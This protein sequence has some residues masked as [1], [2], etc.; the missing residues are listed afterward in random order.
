[1]LTIKALTNE[2]ESWNNY[3]DA[4]P[5]GFIYHRTEWK[6]IIEEHFGKRTHYLM[7]EEDGTVLGILPLIVFSSKLFGKQ[8]YSVPFVNYGGMLFST[9]KAEQALLTEAEKVRSAEGSDAVELRYARKTHENLAEKTQKVTFL[10][11]LPEDE[12]ALMKSFKAKLRSQI[13]R[14]LKENMYAK[15]GGLELLD[16]YYEIFSIN[17]RDLGTPVYSKSFFK[18]ILEKTPQNSHIVIV[19]TEEGKAIGC[20]F[21]IGYKSMME[22]PWAS[23]LRAY[24]KYSPNMMLYWTVLKTAIEK[25]YKQFDFGRCSRDTGTYRF[26][27]QWGAIEKQLYW[28]YILPKGAELPQLNP[29]NPKYKMAINMWQKLPIFLTKIIG[30]QIVKS[31]P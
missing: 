26:K 7:A 24:N 4:H 12:E 1:M 22:I 16:A 15:V 28:N 5:D 11:D 23:T 30:P 2:H 27:K 6:E 14:P 25:G 8:I 21:I 13:R 18:I 20:A 31:L 29:D 10:L 17:M 19:Y 9:A 3:V